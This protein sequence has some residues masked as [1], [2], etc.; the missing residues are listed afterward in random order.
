MPLALVPEESISKGF[1]KNML[2]GA[3]YF[4][5]LQGAVIKRNLRLFDEFPQQEGRNI[6]DAR[7]LIVGEWI[8]RFQIV[9]IDEKCKITGDKNLSGAAES[10]RVGGQRSRGR[11]SEEGNLEAR[12]RNKAKAD[13]IRAGTSLVENEAVI[14]TDPAMQVS[15]FSKKMMAK[16]GHQDGQGLGKDGSGINAPIDPTSRSQGARAGLGFGD[17]GS[18]L[19]DQDRIRRVDPSDIIWLGLDAVKHS[20]LGKTL[21]GVCGNNWVVTGAKLPEILMSKFCQDKTILSLL[22]VRTGEARTQAARQYFGCHGVGKIG[23]VSRSALKLADLQSI[24]TLA[25]QK[26]AP[27][28]KGFFKGD[29]Q[30]LSFIDLYGGQGGFRCAQFHTFCPFAKFASVQYVNEIHAL[31]KYL[32]T[33]PLFPVCAKATTC[34]GSTILAAHRF[35][36]GGC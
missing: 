21:G 36:A 14:A 18:I 20:Q 33:C 1:M 5:Q 25:L 28:L 27:D 3:E 9:P 6:A 13:E 34:C 7:R 30:D 10:N 35:I 26:K 29:E 19:Q 24:V 22:Q 15:E 4:A 11:R 17:S 8:R 32:T 12:K 2:R 31:N 16:M 23:F